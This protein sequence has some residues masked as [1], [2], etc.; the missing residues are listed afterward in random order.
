MSIEERQISELSSGE[1]QKVNMARALIHDPELIIA[2]EPTGNL[3][4]ESTQK[5]ADM[6]I[7]ANKNGKTI[8]LFTH[9][10][11]LLNY[12]KHD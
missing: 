8:L 3:D 5:L 11:H 6:L 12:I 7:Q 10:I 9:D 1:R 4:W 2:D